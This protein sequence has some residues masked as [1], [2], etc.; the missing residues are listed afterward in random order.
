MADDPDEDLVDSAPGEEEV[1][2]D[3]LVV[4][5]KALPPTRPVYRYGVRLVPRMATAASMDEVESLVGQLLFLGYVPTTNNRMPHG[6]GE[7]QVDLSRPTGNLW[8]VRWYDR[9][10]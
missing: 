7:Y 3:A 10:E 4:W 9:T 1:G 6:A 2:V 8:V 5:T